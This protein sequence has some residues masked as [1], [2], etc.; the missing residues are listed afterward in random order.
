MLPRKASN[1][2]GVVGGGA[3]DCVRR[4][5]ALDRARFFTSKS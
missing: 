1:D 2:D 3:I 5:S 4:W